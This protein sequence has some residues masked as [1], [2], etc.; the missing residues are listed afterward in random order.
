[1]K[2]TVQ[3]SKPVKPTYVSSRGGGVPSAVAEA[4]LLTVFDKVNYN[5]YISGINFFRP[6]VPP[7]AVLEAGLARALAEYREWAGR[8][9]VDA[10][11]SRV[12]LLNNAGA[13]FVEATADVTL[14]SVMPPEASP[15][16][17]SLHPDGTG[18]EELMLVQV[19]RF[20]CGSVAVGHTM[21]HIVADGRA[22]SNF[23]LAWGQAA[24]RAS[25]DPVPVHDRA[26]LFVPR[27]PPRVEFDHRGVEFKP[28]GEKKGRG[29]D[30]DDEVVVHRVHFNQEF[31]S[32]LK[33]LASAGAARPISTLQCVAAHLWQCITKARGLDG[34]EVTR[35]RV[36]VDGRARMSTPRV[37]A[38]YTGNVVLWACPTTTAQELTATPLRHAVELISREVSRIDDAYFRS[39]I[40]FANSIAVEEEDLVP[41]ADAAETVLSPDV[42]VD[43][44]LHVP[45]YD[46]DFGGGPPF[47]FMPSYLPVEGSVFVVRS[48]SGARGV[49]A[50]VPLFSRAVDTFKNCC[51]SLAVDARL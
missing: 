6:P 35:L 19:T 34:R 39:F 21:H 41:T 42:E 5:Q 36:A 3:S 48:F 12:I 22:A 45:F 43:S 28:R 30:V 40:D 10:N 25:F 31:L 20:A 8:L 2:I 24:R 13:R 11:D 9:G 1:M 17:L 29:N 50:Y 18:A 38:G 4:V 27:C 49:D 46:L 51:Y 47:F 23:L 16:V 15:E 44:L 32:E 26:S 37:P 7:N 14:D 33:L